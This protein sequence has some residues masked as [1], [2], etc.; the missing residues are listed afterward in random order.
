MSKKEVKKNNR[1]KIFST[2]IILILII[3][4]FVYSFAKIDKNTTQT[5][6][7]KKGKISDEETDIGYIIR[8]ETIIKGENYKNGMIQIVDEG[9][10]VAK[11]ESIFRYF[12]NSEDGTKQEIS[13]LTDEINKIIKESE[14]QSYSSETKSI[15]EEIEANYKK[16]NVQN[17]LQQIK[18]IKKNLNDLINKKAESIGE[19][20]P[21]ESELK[22]LINQKKEYENKLTNGAEYV[23][24]SKSGLLS[25]KIDGLESILVPT[26]F[27]KYNKEFF[28]GLNL[29][30]GQPISKSQEEGKIVDIS[31]CYIIFNSSSEEAKN[32][33][34]GKYIMIN[35]PST[36]EVKAKIEYI[37]KEDDGSN[38]ITVS[39]KDGIEELLNYRK[40]SFDI[41]WWEE[42]GYKVPTSS[43]ITIDNLNYVVRNRSGYL[44]KM[45]VK[46]VKQTEDFSIITSYSS[47]ELSKINVEDSVKKSV[48]LYDEIIEKPT[49]EQIQETEKQY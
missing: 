25:Y 5:F 9:K 39:I 28:E 12:S 4:F 35:L 18:E 20:S 33:E 36:K 1:I 37:T 42:E 7:I 40:V 23:K 29:Q 16:L 48:S 22:K 31:T 44:Q 13:K 27:S 34:V 19:A 17:D 10:K 30:I 21:K 24:S 2:I 43:I 38:T 32:A 26:D 49:E 41:I 8:D 15:D 14:T 45:L 11:N 3:A 6:I 47:D 46:I